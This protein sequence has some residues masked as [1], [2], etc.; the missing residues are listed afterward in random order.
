[1]SIEQKMCEVGYCV[2]G[3]DIQLEQS[4]NDSPVS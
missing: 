4:K 1:M 2:H 3:L